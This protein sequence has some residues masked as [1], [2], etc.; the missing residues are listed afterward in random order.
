MRYRNFGKTG[1]SVSILGFGCMRLPEKNITKDGIETVV[2]DEE[3]AIPMVRK[4]ID[5]GVNYIDTAYGYHGGKSEAFVAKVLADGYRDKVY[6]ADKLP[7]YQV[8]TKEDV[9]SYFNEQLDRLGVE[10]IDFYLLHNIDRNHWKT[11][12][13][14]EILEF[15]E[16]K[17][18]EGKIGYIGFSFHDSFQI[19]KDIVDFYN[20]DFVQIQLNYL[21]EEY[22]AGLEGLE[23]ASSKEMGVVVMEPLRG[24]NLANRLPNIVEKSF[25]A[26]RPDYSFAKWAFKYLYNKSEI[27]VVLSGMSTMDQ[28]MDNVDTA[29]MENFE[30]SK[31]EQEALSLAKQVFKEKIK[32]DCTRCRYCMPCPYG[33]DIPETFRFYNNA[34]LFDDKETYR[35]R[36]KELEVSKHGPS[37]C[38]NCRA[39]MKRCPQGL[40]VPV[41]LDDAVDYLR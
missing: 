10:Y 39:C 26:I 27:S 41:L 12:L 13:D 6:L 14:L 20:W 23:Y 40:K 34:S 11:V 33:V 35:Q 31:E 36:L 28:V 4:A 29:S 24:G 3:L 37:N 2:I 1:K 5:S 19:F 16:R 18:A 15:M 7:V 30:L 22:Q 21:D 8:K 25:S 9:E 38:V 17:K 32:V